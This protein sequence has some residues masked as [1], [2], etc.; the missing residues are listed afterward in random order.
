M[1][2]HYGQSVQVVDTG[3]PLIVF[4][5][6]ARLAR[7]MWPGRGFALLGALSALLLAMAVDWVLP[8]RLLLVALAVVVV[9]LWG[10]AWHRSGLRLESDCLVVQGVFRSE[11]IRWVELVAVELV[12]LA[13]ISDGSGYW[14]GLLPVP[15]VSLPRVGVSA[16]SSDA[17][18]VVRRFVDTRKLDVEV[19]PERP[20]CDRFGR[21]HGDGLEEDPL[22]AIR[23]VRRASVGP[24]RIRVRVDSD[25]FRATMEVARTAEIR[26]QAPIRSSLQ[27]AIND[28]EQL[29][30]V[31]TNDAR[32]IAQ[33]R[34]A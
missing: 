12:W 11:R 10:R 8:A 34:R 14:L 16:L 17:V 23:S 28:A 6:R 30:T 21:W 19:N 24:W 18:A 31:A 32:A 4:V 9:V 5:G 25:G 1:P 20:W 3:D 7:F 15:G 2:G 26:H 22:E 27:E 13:T 33:Q 29:L